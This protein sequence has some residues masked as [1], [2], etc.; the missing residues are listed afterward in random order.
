MS[1]AAAQARLFFLALWLCLCAALPARAATDEQFEQLL[2]LSGLTRQMQEL[3]HVLRAGFEQGVQQGAPL[4]RDV[5]AGIVASV[6]RHI[7]PAVILDEIRY[8]VLKRL[9][10]AD[11]SD[12]LAWYQS[13]FGR[14]ITAAEVAA[15]GAAA[16]DDMAAM[17]DELLA[18]EERVA[19]A[20][21]L[22][23][24]I[25]MSQMNYAIQSEVGAAVYRA[26]LSAVNPGEAVDLAPFEEQMSLVEEDLYA[27]MQQMV[28][29]NIVYTYRDLDMPALERYAEFLNKPVALAFNKSA[30]QGMQ[31]GLVKV[32]DAWVTDVIRVALEHREAQ[33]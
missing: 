4:P 26:I 15:S 1:R 30:A 16:M 28:V 6:D 25:G 10:Q 19:W 33:D 23:A 8:A 22:D 27:M 7:D 5:M 14:R 31:A 20:Q 2:E 17:A 11:I 3:P 18:L 32:M 24:L 13:D 12:L 21:R 29:L 9:D